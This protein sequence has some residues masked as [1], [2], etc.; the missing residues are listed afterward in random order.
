MNNVNKSVLRVNK[1]FK[2]LENFNS[3]NIIIHTDKKNALIQS[4]ISDNRN[5][6]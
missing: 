1:F 3:Y 2:Q 4:K 5:I 6:R